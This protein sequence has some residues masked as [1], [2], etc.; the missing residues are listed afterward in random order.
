VRAKQHQQAAHHLDGI[1]DEHDLAFGQGIGKSAHEGRQDHIEK[2]KHW[3][4]RG[5]LPLGCT[6]GPQQR[7]GTHEKRVVGQRRKELG[8]H[9]RVETALHRGLFFAVLRIRSA[10]AGLFGRVSGRQR[11]ISRRKCHNFEL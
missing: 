11:V 2:G 3:H 9:D 5:L 1:A 4:Q 6:P 8:R 10:N 7:H